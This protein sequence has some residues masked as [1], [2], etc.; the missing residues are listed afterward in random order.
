MWFSTCKVCQHG[1][2][3][4]SNQDHGY[5]EALPGAPVLAALV[6][7]E[8]G[9]GVGRAVGGGGTPAQREARHAES[10]APGAHGAHGAHG[11]A[12]AA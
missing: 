5:G 3:H 10:A 11:T 2:Q 9:G 6:D 12:A 7:V 4:N 1:S 8:P